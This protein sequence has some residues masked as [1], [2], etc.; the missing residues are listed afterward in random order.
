LGT[1][2]TRRQVVEGMG[3]GAL[4]LAGAALLGCGGRSEQAKPTTDASGVTTAA[5]GDGVSDT[6]PLTAPKAQG[7]KR[8]GGTFIQ[9]TTSTYV[10]HDPHTALGGAIYHVIGEKGIEPHPVT[11][12]LLP[13]VLTSW[14]VADPSG[15]TLVFK[16]KQG[17][18][19]HNMAPWNGREFNAED[20]AWN[21]ER[22]GGLYADRLKIPKASFQRATMVGN[23]QKAQAIDPYTVKVTLSKPN[24]SFFAGLMDTPCPSRRR[25]WTTSAGTTR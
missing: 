4:G 24:S 20:V 11:N 25:R 23:I 14:E 3:L 1:A 13:H 10:Q 17:L 2:L 22:I 18:K 16:V 6:L 12:E 15:T 7:K 8:T 19:I 21:M 9:P 5:R